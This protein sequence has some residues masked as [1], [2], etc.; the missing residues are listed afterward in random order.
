MGPAFIDLHLLLTFVLYLQSKD[1]HVLKDKSRSSSVYTP[2]GKG[3][4]NLSA[5]LYHGESI[6]G[7]ATF[8]I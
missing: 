6:N 8:K 7:Y 4:T 3:S 5:D 2:Q 1:T